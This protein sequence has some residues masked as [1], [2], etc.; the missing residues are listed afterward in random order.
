MAN[1]NDIPNLYVLNKDFESVAVL[2]NYS[3]VIWTDR[4]WEPG[5]FEIEVPAS[6]EALENYQIDYYIWNSDSEHMMIIEEITLESNIEEGPSILLAGRSLESILDRR[7]VWGTI[8]LSGNL[9]NA[10]QK[11]LN[12]HVINPSTSS[13]KIDFLSFEN[14]TDEAITSL[15]I[16]SQYTGDTVLDVIQDICQEKEIGFKITMPEDGQWVF[17]LYAGADR[18]YDQNDNPYVIFSPTFENLMNSNSYTSKTEYKTVA[19]VGG[20]GEGSDRTFTSVS[21]SSGAGTGLSRR[22]L[23]VDARD[24]S[25]TVDGEELSDSEYKKQLQQ[26][27]SEKLAENII[28]ETF[29]GEAETT[30]SFT[31]GV[32]FNMGDIV[33]NQNEY[34]QTFTSRIT[35]YIWSQNGSEI[36]E[37]PSFSVIEDDE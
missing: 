33:Q 16:D 11:V 3:S 21:V 10:I 5:D 20:E 28:I 7:I 8:T 14:S 24:L 13:R 22:E 26:R 6:T 37:Y 32:D 35:E 25:S 19:L 12:N 30:N 9:Q 18:S 31:Y 15:T 1:I 2:D 4:F 34:G 23:F 17:K 36:K 27:G 29:E